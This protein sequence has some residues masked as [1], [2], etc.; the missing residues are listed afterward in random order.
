M[1]ELSHKVREGLIIPSSTLSLT[2]RY[3]M[4]RIVEVNEVVTGVL[5]ASVSTAVTVAKPTLKAPTPYKVAT[6]WRAVLSQVREIGPPDV[7]LLAVSPAPPLL[8]CVVD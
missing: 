6:T 5:A 8:D 1:R 2:I 4:T 7:P 3:A